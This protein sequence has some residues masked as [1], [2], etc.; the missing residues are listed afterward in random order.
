MN[1]L[2][3]KKVFA[4]SKKMRITRILKGFVNKQQKKFENWAVN[5]KRRHRGTVYLDFILVSV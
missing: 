3:Y 5:Q 2:L 1:S 4:L